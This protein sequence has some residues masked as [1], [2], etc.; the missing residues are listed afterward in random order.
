VDVPLFELKDFTLY[1]L[2]R[3]GLHTIMLG[4]EATRYTN[5]YT[6]KD[7][8]YTDSSK[9][10]IANMK[11]DSGV[12]K[13]DFVTLL[14][15]V[16]YRRDDGLTFKTQKATYNKKTSIAQS[17]VGYIANFNESV[18]HGSYIQYNNEKN[19]IFSKNVQATIQLQESK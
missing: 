10:Y 15:N 9:G 3:V 1:E 8:D 2:D 11:A 13:N 16:A 19:R 6:V 7:M 5:R 17:T 18:L 14:G 4:S 12:Y